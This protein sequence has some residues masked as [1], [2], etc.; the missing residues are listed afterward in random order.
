L[1]PA[2]NIANESDIATTVSVRLFNM[3]FFASYRITSPKRAFR[4]ALR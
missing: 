2:A 4:F 3:R 1:Q